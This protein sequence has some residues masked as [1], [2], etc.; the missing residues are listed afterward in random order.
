MN[1]YQKGAFLRNFPIDCNFIIPIL[2]AYVPF[3][4]NYEF[5]ALKNHGIKIYNVG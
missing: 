5:D 1:K 2:E 4:E 3:E